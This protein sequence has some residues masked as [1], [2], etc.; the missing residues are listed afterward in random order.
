[1]SVLSPDSGLD[2]A[3]LLADACTQT[4][5]SDFGDAAFREPLARLTESINDEARLTV[6][7][8]ASWRMRIVG[9]LAGRLQRQD[10]IARHPEIEDERVDVRF[11]VS[12]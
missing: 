10:W 11:V 3:S 9:L 8:L 7:G 6:A 12:G 1:M 5:L 4:G 2:A